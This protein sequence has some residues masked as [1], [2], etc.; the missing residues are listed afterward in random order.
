MSK[1]LLGKLA[2]A[3]KW[4]ER[5]ADAGITAKPAQAALEK[6]DKAVAE[7]AAVRVKLADAIEAKNK[8]MLSLEEAMG[9]VKTE[10]KLKAKEAKLQARLASLSTPS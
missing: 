6:A 7:A 4:L 1:K 9:K 3:R 5:N 8:A 10:K 2:T